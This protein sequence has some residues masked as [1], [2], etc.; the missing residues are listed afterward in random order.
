MHIRE[1]SPDDEAQLVTFRCATYSPRG[2]A[3]EI[4]GMIQTRLT[5]DLASG[6][7]RA[8]GWF[9]DGLLALASWTALNEKTWQVSTLAVR[10]GKKR[11][12]LGSWAKREVLRRAEGEHIRAVASH[13]HRDNVGMLDINEKLG[14][15]TGASDRYSEYVHLV[16]P[17]LPEH[18]F[19]WAPTMI[20]PEHGES[21][22][23]L[24][25]LLPT[26]PATVSPVGEVRAGLPHAAPCG[27][28]LVIPQEHVIR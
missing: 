11:Q 22:V 23:S 28:P 10:S 12:R 26:C 15:R 17:V 9:D 3:Q 27:K 21:R 24:R 13:V 5:A 1:L 4:E 14:A 8:L 18:A 20:C 16:I 25:E 7:T 6:R 2:W 19:A